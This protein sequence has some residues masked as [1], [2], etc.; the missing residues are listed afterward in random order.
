MAALGTHFYHRASDCETVP[1]DKFLEPCLG[2]GTYCNC[3]FPNPG[4]PDI[5]VRTTDKVKIRLSSFVIS[6]SPVLQD[7]VEKCRYE[8]IARGRTI[9]RSPDESTDNE[10]SST[11]E[12]SSGKESTSDEESTMD[13]DPV[14]VVPANQLPVKIW[15]YGEEFP[16]WAD[17]P[18]ALSRA[19]PGPRKFEDL[20]E[21]S[22]YLYL[23]ENENELGGGKQ[24]FN[25]T[26]ENE[27][28]P[29]L[30][31]STKLWRFFEKFMSFHLDQ[32]EERE[33]ASR[34]RHAFVHDSHNFPTLGFLGKPMVGVDFIVPP[35]NVRQ[36]AFEPEE[37]E[38][39]GSL[40]HQDYFRLVQ[41]SD[42]LKCVDL[43]FTLEKWHIFFRGFPDIEDFGRKVPFVYEYAFEIPMSQ[44]GEDIWH[45]V[46]YAPK[47]K[48]GCRCGH[49]VIGTGGCM[50]HAHN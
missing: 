43:R 2:C 25:L 6:G 15:K 21:Y 24:V 46:N 18:S 39:F 48:I 45:F 28:R 8:F 27:D 42:E 29:T 47:N 31:I 1:W 40:G 5:V 20:V 44:E 33:I 7:L 34:R 50:A 38:M 13:D 26:P 14:N 30:N 37:E 41:M 32:V 12:S 22:N 11:D 10:S 19:E 16:T 17:P 49:P 35:K 4:Y 36:Y 23:E 9:R 3:D